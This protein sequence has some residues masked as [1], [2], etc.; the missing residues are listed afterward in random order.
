MQLY[1]EVKFFAISEKHYA[2][3]F[4]AYV[5]VINI[6]ENTVLLPQGPIQMTPLLGHFLW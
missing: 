5:Q 1:S 4:S 3:P 6:T 2:F